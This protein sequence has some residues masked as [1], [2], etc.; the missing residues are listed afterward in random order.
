M[1]ILD[2]LSFAVIAKVTETIYEYKDCHTFYW[3]IGRINFKAVELLDQTLLYILCRYCQ[4][5]LQEGCTYL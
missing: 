2:F 3:H 4:T 5:A 1:G